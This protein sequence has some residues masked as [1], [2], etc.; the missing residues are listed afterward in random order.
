M[1]DLLVGIAVGIATNLV[2]WWILF[3]GIRPGIRFSEHIAFA[4]FGPKESDATN[5]VRYRVK[6]QNN[7]WRDIVDVQVRAEFL[8]N[9]ISR[10]GNTLM[11]RIPLNQYGDLELAIPRLSG[12]RP[13]RKRTGRVVALYEGLIQG[14][15]K[16]V[17]LPAPFRDEAEKGQT[18][19]LDWLSLGSGSVLRFAVFGYDGLS[20]ARRLFLSKEYTSDDLRRG[21]YDGLAVIP[22]LHPSDEIPHEA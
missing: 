6:I 20:G 2:A 17:S 7:T 4:P 8:L 11:V 15:E 13:R 1:S 18:S 19:V 12:W 16:R 5:P 14:A 10:T 9:G 22:S 21:W 3:H